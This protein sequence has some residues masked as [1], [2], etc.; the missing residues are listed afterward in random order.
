[1][2]NWIEVCP[3]VGIGV[4][5][6]LMVA[7]TVTASAA[8]IE[9]PAGG[10]LQAAI[11]SAVPGDTILL[12]PGAT[13]VGNFV[14]PVHGGTTY[15]TIRT[16]VADE[17][18]PARGVRMSP[19]YAPY[20]AKIKSPTVAA[21]MRTAAGA[22]FWRLQFLEFLPTLKSQYDVIALGDGSPAQNTLAQVPHHLILDRLYVHGDPLSGQKRGVALN[23]GDTTIVDSY[24]SD[25]KAT[26]QDSQA[27]GGWNGTGPYY[28][29]N[30]Y[31]EATGNGVMIGG[32]DP[33]IPNVTP[34]DIVF[35]GNT[36][37]RP[38][39]WRG[40]I[41]PTPGNVRTGIGTGSLPAGT[42]GYRVMARRTIGAEVAH[43]TPALATTVT[44]S[45]G[46]GVTLT[47]DAVPN[48]ADY[49]VYGRTPTS[50]ANYWVVS[51]T[52]FT[53]AGTTTGSAGTP[54]STGSVWTVKNLFEL[55]NAR[56]VQIDYNLIE[57]NWEQAQTGYAILFTPR[58]QYG[59]CTWC[60][61]EDVVF[62]HNAVRHTG[63][64]ISL[65]GY[66]D[67]HPSQ[68]TNRITIRN[69]EFSDYSQSWGMGYFL[70][71]SNQPRDIVFDHNTIISGKGVGLILASGTPVSGFVFTN[72]LARHDSYG[73]LGDAK[74]IGNVAIS[75]YF[76]DGIFQRN[77][78]AGA[79]ASSYPA[80]NFYPTVTDFVS[81]FRSYATGDFSLLPA[82]NW[83]AA[84]TDGKDLGADIA[85]I[86]GSYSAPVA[87]PPTVVTTSLPPATEGALYAAALEAKGGRAPYKWSLF[88]GTLPPGTQLDAVTGEVIGAPVGYGDSS[89][90][91]Q[92]Q[93]AAGAIS[94]QPLTLH[95]E[96]F[97]PPIE[98]VTTDLAAVK[99][100]AA[101]SQVLEARGASGA[102]VW[103]VAVGALPAGVAL[104]ASG[105]IA[106]TA[107]V[108]GIYAVTL[109]V[110]DAQDALRTATRS[111]ELVVQAE[112]NIEPRVSLTSSAIGSAPL[113]STVTLTAAATDSDGT[114]SRVN[115][116][117]DGALAATATAAPYTF[118]WTA[119][120]GT[121]RF[122]VLAVDDSGASTMST[123]ASIT[124]RV[125]IVLHATDVTKMAGV[126]QLNAD[127]GAAGGLA[128][129]N[130]NRNA[131]KLAGAAAAPATY[132]EF[133]FYAEA[134]R[135]YHLWMRSRAQ[136]NDYENDSAFVQFSGIASARIGST[137]AMTYQL[138]DA[139]SAGLSSWGWQDNGLG[140]V[141]GMMGPHLIFEKSGL[142]T[143]RIQPREDGLQID[144]IVISP[145]RY[146]LVA[147][148]GLKNDA[149]II[150]R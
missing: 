8:T 140:T 139:P 25:M 22:A 150:A 30:N 148:G 130:Q 1:M 128:L 126:F 92:L 69:N 144:Q 2:R 19:A 52:S 24:I 66:D 47:W 73:I 84:G 133:Q 44:V 113:A 61:V 40:V 127:P 34:T 43:S 46:A 108:K 135:P 102:Y 90:T 95:V 67:E 88:S 85:S 98:I 49:V 45:S 74:G 21:A 11:N 4:A 107:T 141:N 58:N 93:D 115:L 20:L 64:A 51:G 41:I 36:V 119:A 33:K 3:S 96:K 10:N 120:A 110:A 39:S 122:S 129:W 83:A 57:N 16:G 65:T 99:I 112:G 72:N 104:N 134:G 42:Y 77:V 9:V 146:L 60:V 142:Q 109:T 23:S 80:G 131:K 27:I 17:L 147:P 116:Y 28:I 26:G 125:E 14:L 75:Y 94:R 138:E 87:D 13:Y 79:S 117:V 18:L 38:A 121:H 53:D 48:A 89:F 70:S 103:T 91:V 54:P 123:E 50:Q 101:F 71:I 132:A 145:D 114:I 86:F 82:T 81:H 105:V 37:T 29:A 59:S 76:P 6:A 31:L 97:I 136:K 68:Q 12:A 118:S 149:T 56:H 143:I 7:V 32:D 5:A 55:K 137:G 78:I 35:R 100:T 106:G 15:V 124:T 63:G 111:F 62:E